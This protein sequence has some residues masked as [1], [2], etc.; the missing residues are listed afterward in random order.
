MGCGMK[1]APLDVSNDR[2][3]VESFISA[4]DLVTS[5]LLNLHRFEP[6][7]LAFHVFCAS[8]TSSSAV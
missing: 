5:L 6:V 3:V 7:S 1:D 8:W 4:I 2:E